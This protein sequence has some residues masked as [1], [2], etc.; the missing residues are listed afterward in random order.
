MG[1]GYFAGN[2]GPARL[3]FR[4]FTLGNLLA[5]NSGLASAAQS[6]AWFELLDAQREELVGVMP[7][8]LVYPALEGED[9][10]RMTGADPKNAA[11]SYHN[12]GTWPYLAWPLAQAARVVGSP[13]WP[14]E[15][16][17]QAAERLDRDSWPEYYDGPLGGLIGRTARLR[18]SWTAAGVLAADALLRNPEAPDPFGFEPDAELE[19]AIHRGSSAEGEEC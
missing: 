8:K 6:R 19:A 17:A 3:D 4:I 5:V 7:L 1:G 15:A 13:D 11:W 2:L 14:A 18:Q 10:R 12:G 16:I 9:W